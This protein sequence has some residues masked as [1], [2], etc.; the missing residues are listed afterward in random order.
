[1]SNQLSQAES[2]SYQAILFLSFGG[3]DGPE[4]VMP[5]LENVTRGRNV[6]RERLIEVAEH[7][8]QFGGKSPINE[9][10]LALID[11][12]RKELDDHGLDHLPI[13][14]GNRNW[15]PFLVD[16]MAEMAS[17]GIRKALCFVTSSFSS[18]SGCRQYRE[19]I[20]A[21]RSHVG[22]AAPEIDKIRVW[23]NHPL[24]VDA[25]ADRVREAAISLPAEQRESALLVFT[26]HS[27]PREMADTSEYVRQLEESCRLVSEALQNHPYEL[28]YQSRSGSP[29]QPWLEPD[30]GDFIRDRAAENRKEALIVSPIGFVSD[31]MEVMFDLDEEAREIGN[32][33]GIP[34]VRALSVGTHPSFVKMIR[35][36][37]EERLDSNTKRLAIGQYGPGRDVCE[38]DCCPSPAMLA[39][40]AKPRGKSCVA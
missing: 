16:T 40:G 22:A 29:L 21:A 3:P 8:L 27:I 31:H 14:F 2:L 10:N 39:S 33:L 25:M 7:Y 18:Y 9:Q 11:A 13:Y 38:K 32:T 37:I 4:D 28:V 6:P 12:T 26:A 17:A 36:L 24:F 15:R 23:Y 1:M 35:M 30:I 19:D 34:M 20:L 5:F